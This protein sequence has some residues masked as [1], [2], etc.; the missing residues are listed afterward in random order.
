MSKRVLILFGVGVLLLIG[1][2]FLLKYE[3]S[4]EPEAEPEAESEAEPKVK[5][6]KVMPTEAV[7]DKTLLNE[8]GSETAN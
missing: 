5:K 8:A 7:T 1:A 6:T 2:L 4:T 3:L